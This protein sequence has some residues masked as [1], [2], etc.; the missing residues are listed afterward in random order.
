MVY[1]YGELQMENKGVVILANKF[2]LIGSEIGMVA[3]ATNFIY[4][5]IDLITNATKI[6]IEDYTFNSYPSWLFILVMVTF[7][8]STVLIT[9]GL[10]IAYKG[11]KEEEQKT[12]THFAHPIIFGAF[13]VLLPLRYLFYAL[14]L[15]LTFNAGNM[16]IGGLYVG[17][18]LSFTLTESI[19]TVILTSIT[20][21]VLIVAQVFFWKQFKSYKEKYET[22]TSGFLISPFVVGVGLVFYL[23]AVIV[24]AALFNT[25]PPGAEVTHVT[26]Y[27]VN[28]AANCF[29]EL[30]FFVTYLELTFKFIYSKP[31]MT[32]A[33]LGK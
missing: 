7:V 2:L 14:I 3:F 11:E 19:L 4:A 21:G 26:T 29:M 16:F 17:G 30:S 12:L 6:D 10:V 5:L 1:T 32:R 20:V 22:K 23:V 8:A 24:G 13:G 33:E 28:S 18:I 31:Q 27:F 15:F 9:I 25:P